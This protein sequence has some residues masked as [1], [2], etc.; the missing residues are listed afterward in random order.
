MHGWQVVYILY[1]RIKEMT[2]EY[3]IESKEIKV[4]EW[5]CMVDKWFKLYQRIKE[6]TTEYFIECKEIKD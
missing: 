1:Q 6:M 3:Y 4:L 5:N 2:T